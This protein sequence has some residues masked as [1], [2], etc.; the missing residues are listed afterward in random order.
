LEKT[1]RYF[2]ALS[3]L[4]DSLKAQGRGYE[5]GLIEQQLRDAQKNETRATRR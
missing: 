5:A 1:P 4:R 3:G 2:R